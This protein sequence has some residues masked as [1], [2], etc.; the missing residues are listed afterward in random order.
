[1][2]LGISALLLS[3]SF[4]TSINALDKIENIQGVDKYETAG[5]ISDKQDF[6]TAVLINAD[7]TMV[8][9]IAQVVL[10]E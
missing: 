1:M 9:G 7:S 5:L 4:P 6:T 2:A 10:Q 3:V 8:D